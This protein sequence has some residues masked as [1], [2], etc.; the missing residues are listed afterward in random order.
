MP[1]NYRF[2]SNII[3]IYTAGEYTIND[4]RAA[5]LNSLVDPERPPNSFLLLNFGESQIIYCRSTQEIQKMTDF[6]ASVGNHYNY[7]FAIVS[8]HD[9]P[10]VL[11]HFVSVRSGR[12]GITSEVFQ[13]FDEAREWLVS[14]YLNTT[15]QAQAS[16][17]THEPQFHQT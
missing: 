5:L 4:L 2:D 9:L 7:R 10:Y 12:Y 15:H 1:V 8:S 17:T 13:T 3:V 11:Q 16:P 14:E 6:V